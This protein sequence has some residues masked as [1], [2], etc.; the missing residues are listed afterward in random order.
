MQGLDWCVQYQL[1]EGVVVRFQLFVFEQGQVFGDVLGVQ[2]QV[3][4]GLVGE[5]VEFVG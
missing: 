3:Y 5:V 1:G 2:V 4:W